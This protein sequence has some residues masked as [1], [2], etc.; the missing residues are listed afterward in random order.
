MSFTSR[1]GPLR[2]W[3]PM[4][5]A[6]S[7]MMNIIT[8]N[9]DAT[10]GKVLGTTVKMSSAWGGNFGASLDICRSSR[11]CMTVLAGRRFLLCIAALKE[12]PRSDAALRA[13]RVAELVHLPVNGKRLAAY[14]G[15]RKQGPKPAAAA[16]CCVSRR[17]SSWMVSLPP[18]WTRKN[19]YACVWYWA[20]PAHDRAHYCCHHHVVRD[21]EHVASEI[22]LLKEGQLVDRASPCRVWV[23]KYAPGGTPLKIA[24]LAFARTKHDT[25]AF[26]RGCGSGTAV[27]SLFAFSVCRSAPTCFCCGSARAIRGQCPSLCLSKV[28]TGDFRHEHGGYGCFLREELARTE[29]LSHIYNHLAHRSIQQRSKE[30]NV[31]PRNLRR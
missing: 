20:Q 1:P 9:L 18:D 8:G 19:V 10:S 6:K 13:Q 31:S 5:Q 16:L 21:V 22:P 11:I 12:I 14:S 29:G 26:R 27:F 3:G 17:S 4:A 28:G 30:T 15:G 24:Y 23:E 2:P 7:T 25:P